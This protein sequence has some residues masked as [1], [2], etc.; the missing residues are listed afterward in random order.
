MAMYNSGSIGS[1]KGRFGVVSLLLHQINISD[2]ILAAPSGYNVF[3]RV[4]G[5]DVKIDF[6]PKLI[7]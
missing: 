5:L 4:C 3:L 1:S 6:V 7:S 2:P